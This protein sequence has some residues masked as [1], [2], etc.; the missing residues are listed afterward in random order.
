MEK[1]NICFL[2]AASPKIKEEYIKETEKLG[3]YLGKKFNLVFGG[4]SSGLMGAIARGFRKSNSYIT[5][6][7][8]SFIRE[9]EDVYEEC[10]DLIEV[11]SMHERKKIME[12]KADLFVVGPGGVGTLDEFFEVLTDKSLNRYK[13]SVILFNIDSFYDDIIRYI[14]NSLNSGIIDKERFSDFYICNSVEEVKNI[15]YFIN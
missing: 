1:K 11:D 6:V 10:N 4:S 9:F 13:K 2:G 14:N 3:E 12:D 15:L 5:G 8:P 7:V